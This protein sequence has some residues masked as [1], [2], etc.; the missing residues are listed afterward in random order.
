MP[1]WERERGELPSPI[2]PLSGR[3]VRAGASCSLCLLNRTTCFR[4]TSKSMPGG[5]SKSDSIAASRERLTSL[6]EALLDLHKTLITSERE[7]YEKAI[8]PIQSPNHF[9]QLLTTDP[10]F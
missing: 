6:R 4:L 7:R 10:W 2:W 5:S 8:G 9:L 1:A 3:L